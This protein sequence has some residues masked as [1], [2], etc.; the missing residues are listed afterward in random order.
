MELMPPGKRG[1]GEELK[2]MGL[3]LQFLYIHLSSIPL[4]E[5]RNSRETSVERA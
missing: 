4:N 1:G 2:R 3:V 5:E